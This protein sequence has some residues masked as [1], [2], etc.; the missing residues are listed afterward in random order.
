MSNHIS[1]SVDP[2]TCRVDARTDTGHAIPMELDEPDGPNPVEA[3][4]AGLPRCPGL[5]VA[6]IQRKKR[7]VP[8]TDA[9]RV[10]SPLKAN[11][12]WLWSPSSSDS[13][14]R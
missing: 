1:A 14:S 11:A 4:L 9:I 3:R 6:T 5:G 2:I 12:K 10:E 13:I 7:P 8:P